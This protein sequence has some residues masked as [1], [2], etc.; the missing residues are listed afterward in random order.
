MF[1]F[2]FVF[3]LQFVKTIGKYHMATKLWSAV[4]VGKVQ[5]LALF[6]IAIIE[7]TSPRLAKKLEIEST[8]LKNAA[9]RYSD[10]SRRC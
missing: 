3:F 4:V 1:T 2:H 9:R 8:R 6:A 5:L 10:A 7:I